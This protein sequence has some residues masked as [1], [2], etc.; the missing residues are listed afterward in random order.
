MTVVYKRPH[1]RLNVRACSPRNLHH[2]GHIENDKQR[3]AGLQSV[4]FSPLL[5]GPNTGLTVPCTVRLR[6]LSCF[7]T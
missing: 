7:L 5:L 2:T 4:V 1:Q 6:S 3:V